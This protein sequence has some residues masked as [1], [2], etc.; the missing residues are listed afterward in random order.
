MPPYTFR[1]RGIEFP[2]GLPLPINAH[3][4]VPL[5]L[6]IL[7]L[8]GYTGVDVVFVLWHPDILDILVYHDTATGFLVWGDYL[9]LEVELGEIPSPDFEFLIVFNFAIGF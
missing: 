8:K 5:V 7:N 9:V 6:P 3:Y 2:G 1:V 4:T